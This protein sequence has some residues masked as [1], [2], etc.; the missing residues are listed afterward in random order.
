MYISLKGKVNVS[1]VFENQLSAKIRSMCCLGLNL[2]AGW[3]CILFSTTVHDLLKELAKVILPICFYSQKTKAKLIHLPLSRTSWALDVLNPLCDTS[4]YH[5]FHL[6]WIVFSHQVYV[7]EFTST[8]CFGFILKCV[9]IGIEFATHLFY[10]E[11]FWNGKKGNGKEGKGKRM[12]KQEFTWRY[13][14]LEN[15]IK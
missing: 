5:Y 15:I 8:I 3:P 4:R 1:S 14:P 11:F 6:F 9:Y 13:I 10:T 2:K 12:G 7:H